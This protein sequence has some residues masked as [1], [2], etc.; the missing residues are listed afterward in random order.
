[1]KRY[2]DYLYLTEETIYEK[3]PAKRLFDLFRLDTD[4]K[5]PIF[6]FFRLGGF[7]HKNFKATKG[8]NT[9][10]EY[11]IGDGEYAAC[12]IS[13]LTESIDSVFYGTIF[14]GE[15]VDYWDCETAKAQG[16]TEKKIKELV[17]KINNK[18]INGTIAIMTVYR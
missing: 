2:L 11:T 14:K 17:E 10:E 8:I 3:R 4:I 6:R 18:Q 7:L 12:E 1:M 15:I 5:F 13:D 9:K 16:E